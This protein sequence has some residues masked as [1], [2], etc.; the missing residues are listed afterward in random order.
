MTPLALQGLIVMK[1]L[2]CHYKYSGLFLQFAENSE[3]ENGLMVRHL[4]RK[5]ILKISRNTFSQVKNAVRGRIDLP[6]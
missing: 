5:V 1:A 6:P 3:A 2:F 4:L